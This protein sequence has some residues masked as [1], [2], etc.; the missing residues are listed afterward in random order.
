M[1]WVSRARGQGLPRA[2]AGHSVRLQPDYGVLGNPSPAPAAALRAFP[3]LPGDGASPT[4]CPTAP[5][6]C[7][8]TPSSWDG[9]WHAG[10]RCVGVPAA[11][12][13]LFGV[14]AVVSALGFKAAGIAAGS[15]AAK[16]MS[17]AAIANNGGV[18]AGSTVAVLQSV[19]E[20]WG[21][22]LR[23]DPA[24]SVARAGVMGL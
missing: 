1:G 11:G 12:V 24:W 10:S 23:W 8:D 16:M 3:L 7:S 20:W 21:A 9:T 17:A 19:G 13:V 18:A 5:A 22:E 4:L 14:P 15:I 2:W 6:L